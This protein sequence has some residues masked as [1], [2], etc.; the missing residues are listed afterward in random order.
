MLIVVVGD[1]TQN[2]GRERAEGSNDQPSTGARNVVHVACRISSLLKFELHTI[3]ILNL[4]REF[5]VCQTK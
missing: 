4:F 3:I 1:P 5:V 2:L